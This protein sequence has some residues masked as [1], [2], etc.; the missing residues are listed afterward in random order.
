MNSL[1]NIKLLKTY[2]TQILFSVF[3]I[4]SY[5]VTAQSGEL[6]NAK[7]YTIGEISVSGNTSF[8]SET[9]ITYSGLRAGDEIMIPG[10]KISA[11]IKKLWSSNL[12]SDVDVYSIQIEGDVVYLEI[13]L[14]D[15]PELK[16]VK[17][18]GV[19]KS[20]FEDILKE[21]KLQTGA[22]VTE[23]LITTTKNYL[24]NKYKK[25]GF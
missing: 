11:A 9:I 3:L 13:Q 17:I 4:S 24:Q 14:T 10:E 12:F 7:K 23:N 1:V 5:N 8:G 6:A 16:D 19:K 21:N 2:I 18:E 15:L 25:Q 20:K 22:K